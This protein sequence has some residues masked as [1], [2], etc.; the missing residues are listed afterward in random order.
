MLKRTCAF[1]IVVKP[2]TQ[3]VTLME[4][5]VKMPDLSQLEDLSEALMNLVSIEEH[6]FFSFVKSQKKGYL[7]LLKDVRDVRKELLKQVSSSSE[8]RYCIGKHCLAASMRLMEAGTKELDKG[9]V[10]KAVDFFNKAF[11]VYSLFFKLNL[12]ENVE[13]SGRKQG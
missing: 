8:E 4:K 3:T 2:V 12:K 11:I 5:R 7:E 1:F 13:K 10:D 6:L 9:S